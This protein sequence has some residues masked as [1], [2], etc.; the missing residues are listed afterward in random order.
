MEGSAVTQA[1]L[2][3]FERAYATDKNVGIVLQA[4]LKRTPADVERAIGMDARVRLCK[5]AYNE[6]PEIAIKEMPQ[7]Q[8]QYLDTCQAAARTW[9][10]SRAC[11]ARSR[12]DRCDSRLR[13]R[14]QH[15]TPTA[16]NFKC[17]T[18]AAP[19]PTRTRRARISHARLRPVRNPLGRLFLPPRAWNAA[20]TP[21]LPFPPCSRNSTDARR[22]P[23]RDQRQ[24]HAST[25]ASPAN[26][27]RPHGLP[28]R[29]RSRQRSRRAIY[30]AEK[31]AHL[32]IFT[33]EAGLMNRSVHRERAE[34]SYSSRNSRSTAMPAKAD[35]RRSSTPQKNHWQAS[36]TNAS[37]ASSKNSD[38]P[39]PT[40]NSAPTCKWNSRTTAP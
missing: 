12:A 34:R 10:L 15:S 1:T 9:T 19:A 14:T 25:N 26:R 32:R 16:S 35:A 24:R 4:Y 20:K 5:G 38:C 2:D 6:P 11:N 28:R 13:A 37:A 33:D 22:R 40:A 29:R 30:M 39:S 23:T 36:S 3:L 17:S 21:S 8:A 7:I 31:I 18:D 27:H